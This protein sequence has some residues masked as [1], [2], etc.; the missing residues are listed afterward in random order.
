MAERSATTGGLA[1]LGAR[2][3]ETVVAR[4]RSLYADHI[5]RGG[6]GCGAQGAWC[7]GETLAACGG[8]DLMWLVYRM[9]EDH[10]GLA[11]AQWLD[12]SWDG[13]KIEKVAL[14]RAGEP[15]AQ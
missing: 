13:V 5:E 8:Y 11:C 2:E 7:I 4:V 10:H 14:W 15:H 9:I 6:E 3:M 12:Q 1:G